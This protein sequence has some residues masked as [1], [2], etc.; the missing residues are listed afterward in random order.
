MA[1]A[2]KLTKKH[3]IP[4]SITHVALRALAL[5]ISK[6]EDIQG[7]IKWG[8]VSSVYYKFERDENVG[9]TTLVNVDQGKDLVPIHI[10]EPTKIDVL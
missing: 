3:G 5:G 6:T 8:N 10:K 4:V 2:A 9:V 1:F 7:I